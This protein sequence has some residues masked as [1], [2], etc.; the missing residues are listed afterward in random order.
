MVFLRGEKVHF[1]LR[2]NTDEGQVILT[3]RL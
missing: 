2:L 3:I 1:K